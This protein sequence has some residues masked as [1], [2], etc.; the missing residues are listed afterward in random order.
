MLGFTRDALRAAAQTLG[1]SPAVAGVLGDGE[2][3][4]AGRYIAKCNEELQKQ[5]ESMKDQ[6]AAM[7]P[8][9]RLRT[10]MQLRLQLL[11][12]VLKAWPAALA[13]LARPRNAPTSLALALQTV[14][15][16]LYAAGDRSVGADWYMK[17]YAGKAC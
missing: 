10:A 7:S 14:S 9:Q 11:G 17:R 15:E 13:A 4:M 16:V 8:H 12:P 3:A 5:V 6:M 1:L 2:A